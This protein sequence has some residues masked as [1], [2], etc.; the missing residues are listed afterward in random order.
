MQDTREVRT[1]ADEIL[2]GLRDAV[3]V[4]APDAPATLALTL[5]PPSDAQHGDYAANAAFLLA[6]SLRRPPLAV[7]EDLAANFRGPADVSAAAPGFLNFRIHPARLCQFL[8]AMGDDGWSRSRAGAGERV[9]VEYVSANPTGPL[10]VGHGRGAVIGDTLVRL[11]AHAGFEVVREYY[12]NDVGGQVERLGESLLAQARLQQGSDEG[13]YEVSYPV[14]DEAAAWLAQGGGTAARGDAA[15]VQA[16]AAFAKERLLARIMDDLRRLGITFDVVTHES[17]LAPRI[18]ALIE[19]L[20]ASGML[21]EAAEAE[22]SVEVVRRADSKAAQHRGAME[23]GT[24]L[25]TS[26]FGDETD[27]V[28]L[29][30]NGSPTYFT[31]DIVY[32]LEKAER[33]FQRLINV[34]GADHG[35]HV[36]RLVAA[37]EAAAGP[38]G[39]GGRLEVVLCQMVRL[40]R[41][42]V[43]VKMSKRAG[44][45]ISLQDLVEEVGRDAVRFFFLLRSPHA[46]FDF[47]LDLAVKQSAD[48]PVFYVQYAHARTRQLLAKGAEHGLAP[49]WGRSRDARVETTRVEELLTDPAELAI[50]RLLARLPTSIRAAALARETHRLPAL[51]MELAQTLHQ[52]QT[53]GKARDDLR[54]VRPDEPEITRARLFLIERT[55][56][57]LKVLLEDL[58]G[59]NA[60]ERM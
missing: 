54:I 36:K 56:R 4:V 59:V 42:G 9:N 11:M 21:Y 2:D 33:G 43:E 31:S 5:G 25:R 15:L 45:A 24:F 30:A 10:H 29:R 16:A 7:A 57:A 19:T 28:I 3:R 23:G 53:Q 18:P 8:V 27:R 51:A 32:H 13:G 60:P 14:P 17:S 46:Q 6:K 41:G 48:N 50:I 26:R 35:G 34:W 1:I 55:G 58:M 44:T 52:Y 40:V 37:L 47:D 20:R 12:V 49:E 39:P 38:D 22:G